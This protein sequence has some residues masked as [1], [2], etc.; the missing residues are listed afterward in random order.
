MSTNF[1]AVKVLS[2]LFHQSFGNYYYTHHV[3]KTKVHDNHTHTRSF[4]FINVENIVRRR[5]VI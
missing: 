5:L 4:F 3:N 1:T 2:V